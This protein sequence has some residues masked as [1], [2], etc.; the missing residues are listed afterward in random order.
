MSV[1]KPRKSVSCLHLRELKVEVVDLERDLGSAHLP[2]VEVQ[3]QK[4]Y[5]ELSVQLPC[6]YG[7]SRAGITTCAEQC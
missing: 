2:E 3:E 5:C 6:L 4:P 1:L 7:D